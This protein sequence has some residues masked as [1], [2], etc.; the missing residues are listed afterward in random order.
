MGEAQVVF[1]GGST[2]TRLYDRGKLGTGNHIAGPAIVLQ[3]DTTARLVRCG[4]R[5]R[6]PDAGGVVSL[7]T[8]VI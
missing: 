2:A 6:Q 4:G 7:E 1:P 8:A 3:M 5:L